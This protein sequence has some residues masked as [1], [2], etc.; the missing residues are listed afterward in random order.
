MA[1]YCVQSNV[2]RG[3]TKEQYSLLREMCQYSNNLYNVALYNIR[4][5]YFNTKKFLTY[6]SNYHEC[7]TNENYALLQAGVS[8]QIMKVVD[9]S[10]KS[11]F[12]LLKKCKTGDYRYHDVNIPHYRKKGGMFNLIMS[13]NAFTVKNGFLYVPMSRAFRAL[14][15]GV[16]EIK[17]KFPERLSDKIVKEVRILPCNH[18]KFFKIQYVYEVTPKE[19]SLNKENC[20]SIDFGVD[21]LATCVSTNGTPFIIDGRKLKSINHYWNKEMA[22]LRSISMKQGLKTT[23][24]IQRITTKRNNRV[25]DTIKKAA[26]CIINYCIQNDVGT[27][28]VGYTLDFKRNTNIGKQNN[29]NFVQIPLGNLRQQLEFLCWKYNIDYIEQEESYTS[30]SSFLDNDVLP[31]YKAEQPYQGEFSGKRIKRGLYQSGDGTILNADVNGAANILRKCKQN[32]NF[33][34]LCKGLLASPKRIRLS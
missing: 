29:Q 5:H 1:T 34:K 21:N 31:E 9:R 12:N 33:E 14:H 27:L 16:K 23:D 25:N 8:Q 15:S 17:V 11:F 20:L 2:I 18:G 4:Q 13:T 6:E 10:F 30:K 3:L 32:L 26:R 24:K 28:I 7:K 19:I 22:R